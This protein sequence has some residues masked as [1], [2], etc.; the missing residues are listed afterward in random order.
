[1]TAEE[2]VKFSILFDMSVGDL[3]HGQE[4]E[5]PTTKFAGNLVT[6]VKKIKSLIQ[7]KTSE[8]AKT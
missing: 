6:L 5:I 1:M 2:T 7:F 4:T 8:G 3:L